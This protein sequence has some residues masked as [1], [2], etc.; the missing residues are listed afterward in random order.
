VWSAGDS[1]LTWDV[2]GAGQPERL[3]ERYASMISAIAV[4]PDGALLAVGEVEGDIW[5]TDLARGAD[6][7]RV[8]FDPRPTSPAKA[9]AFAPGQVTSEEAIELASAHSNG[10]IRLWAVYLDLAFE[11]EVL[12]G[13]RDEALAVAFR[14]DG[15]LVS[16]GYDGELL[17]WSKAP[18]GGLAEALPIEGDVH[19][20][21]VVDVALLD[22]HGSAVVSLDN[23]G[24]LIVSDEDR[25]GELRLQVEGTALALDATD[26][27]LAYSHGDGSIG[28][29]DGARA[30]TGPERPL[31]GEH[32]WGPDILDLSDD[33][34]ALISIADTAVV[35]DVG[36]GSV[37]SRLELPADFAAATA[38]Y[39]LGDRVWIGGSDS[40]G[41]MAIEL[42]A[43]SG[44][45]VG[46]PIRHGGSFGDA[47]SALA[48]S[49]DG[50]ILATGGTD[51]AIRLWDPDTH[52]A[53]EH[54]ELSGHREIVT[55]MVFTADSDELISVDRDNI[56]NLWHV[57]ERQLITV[58]GGP[59]DGI[60]ALALS[61]D[62]LTLVVASED[63]SVYRWT[64]D[65]WDWIE[66]AC[67]LAAR[68]M[69]SD[70]WRLYGEGPQERLCNYPGEGPLFDWSDRVEG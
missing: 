70:E 29:L 65:Q 69:T 10:A 60:N 38:L 5:T 15:A 18:I 25:T 22:Q 24:A 28:V 57:A 17:W 56:V 67:Q 6:A 33:G 49:P 21:D 44:E 39:G 62:G 37:R 31:S 68:N 23:S 12:R 51:R 19:G 8:E 34:Q 13:H 16:G 58:F 45:V 35:W 61:A 20:I 50:T 11:Q 52:V 48:L 40:A 32:A 46:E 27:V 53:L 47:V 14:R 43:S 26:D 4:S 7:P 36:K 30:G 64:L 2:G 9:L 55:G 63:D 54:D 42:D 1:V 59:T 41:P 3:G 66:R